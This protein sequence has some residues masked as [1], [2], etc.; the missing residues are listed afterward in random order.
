[1]KDEETI[2]VYGDFDFLKVCV[3]V[4]ADMREDAVNM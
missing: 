3:K 1:M 4:F 2:H